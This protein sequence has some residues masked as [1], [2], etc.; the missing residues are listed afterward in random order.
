M[1]SPT[2]SNLKPF[3]HHTIRVS[4]VINAPL[5]FVYEWCTDYR[6]DDNKIIG[7]TTQR[8]ILQRTRQRVIYLSIYKRGAKTTCAVSIVT[9]RPPKAWHLDY[10]GEEYDETGDYRLVRL[11]AQ[12]TRLSMVFRERYKI[13]DAP[14]KAEDTKQV[15]EIWNK[16]AAALEGDYGKVQLT[17]W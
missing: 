2:R 12:R 3:S 8:K 4:K 17:E 7:S 14:T 13:R 1:R 16:Y 5:S 9:L 11:G 10:V 6:E 15:R